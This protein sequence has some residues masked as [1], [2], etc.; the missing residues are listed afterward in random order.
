MRQHCLMR[1]LA[2][3][4]WYQAG[5]NL[6]NVFWSQKLLLNFSTIS[7]LFYSVKQYLCLS[8]ISRLFFSSAWM[9][10]FR[11]IDKSPRKLL[12]NRPIS[13]NRQNALYPFFLRNIT[14]FVTFIFPF[15]NFSLCE[16]CPNTEFF[17]VRIFSHLDWIRT[18]KISVF[19]HFSPNAYQSSLQT[20]QLTPGLEFRC[21]FL[22]F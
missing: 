3:G 14:T 12:T 18:R 22:V 9:L 5:W 21:R 13:K 6:A 10:E 17:L 2:L 8:T 11:S 16:M 4:E 7:R 20:F 19:E 15:V 1:V